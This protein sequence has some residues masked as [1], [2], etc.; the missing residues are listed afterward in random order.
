MHRLCQGALFQEFCF[1]PDNLETDLPIMLRKLWM[2]WNKSTVTGT[3]MIIH[4]QFKQQCLNGW[5][6][7]PVEF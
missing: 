4:D 5:T 3:F 7:N 6:V 1:Y 2:K